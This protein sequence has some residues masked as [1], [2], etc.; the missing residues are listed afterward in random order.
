MKPA[1]PVTRM[2]SM[3]AILGGR[4]AHRIPARQ[5]V[6]LVVARPPTELVLADRREHR[7]D[8][9][10]VESYDAGAVDRRRPPVG[11]GHEADLVGAESA[12]G[13]AEGAQLPVVEAGVDREQLAELAR[14]AGDP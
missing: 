1:P 4:S 5:L 7:P 8:R 12:A 6:D 9:G 14:Q 10:Y 13:E 11:H 3:A 2:R